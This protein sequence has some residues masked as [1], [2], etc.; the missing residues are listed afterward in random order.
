MTES[1]VQHHNP[2]LQNQAITG[3]EVAVFD[4]PVAEGL[5]PRRLTPEVF[6][7]TGPPSSLDFREDVNECNMD[8]HHGWQSDTQDSSEQFK[9]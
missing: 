7:W 1:T 2:W 4:G 9:C 8:D 6:Q 5:T 3:Q